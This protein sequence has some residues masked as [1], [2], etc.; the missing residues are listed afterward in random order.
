MITIMSRSN[1]LDHLISISEPF[2]V[3]KVGI[4]ECRLLLPNE[5]NS[6]F[7]SPGQE[8][9][10]HIP[11]HIWTHE[12]LVQFEVGEYLCRGV[13][14]ELWPMSAA[15]FF[16]IRKRHPNFPK[17]EDNGW[18][19]FVNFIPVYAI[20]MLEPF[21]VQFTDGTYITGATG[22]FLMYC[23]DRTAVWICN[24]NIFR[25]TYTSVE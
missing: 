7:F 25:E 14:G 3:L 17:D 20:S 10:P 4:T 16:A 21:K 1:A 9:K 11:G 18:G 5:Y 24:Q 22:D 23:E 6:C 13:N 19:K 2:K 12:G 15:D 8:S